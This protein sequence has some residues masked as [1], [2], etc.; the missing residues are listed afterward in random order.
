M[1]DPKRTLLDGTEAT[2]LTFVAENPDEY[3]V[4]NLEDLFGQ[5]RPEVRDIA[6]ALLGEHELI[7]TRT[8]EERKHIYRVAERFKRGVEAARQNTRPYL[9]Q[10]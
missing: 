4:E 1:T 6:A 2:I 9:W 5:V 7:Q 8:E 10:T 3:H